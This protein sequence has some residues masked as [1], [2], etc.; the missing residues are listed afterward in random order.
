MLNPINIITE[1]G[2]RLDVSPTATIEVN[3]GGISLLDL[4]SRTATY[5]NS[6][7]LPRTPTNESVFE[8]ASQPTRN[9]RPSIN[10]WIT[11][12]LFQRKAKLKVKSFEDSYKCS[13]SYD[14]EDVIGIT[15]TF[16]VKNL[17]PATYLINAF[18]PSNPEPTNNDMVSFICGEPATARFFVPITFGHASAVAGVAC[19]KVADILDI[20]STASG[21][22]FSGDIL[23]DA[24]FL[25]T[26]YFEKAITFEKSYN[27]DHWEINQINTN[28]M[29]D[30][31]SIADILKVLAQIYA[32][33]IIVSE[34]NIELK[35]L[36][37]LL[38]NTATN[39]ETIQGSKDLYSGYANVNNIVYKT[40][41]TISKLFGSDFITDGSGEG[42][43]NIVEINS[44]IPIFYNGTLS[45]YDLQSDDAMKEIVFMQILTPVT[46][47]MTFDGTTFDTISNN[48]I[49]P[50]SMSG[51]YSGILNPIFANP[52]ILK[53]SGF[54][55]PLTA[56]TIM[57]DRIINSVR[58]GGRYWVEPMAYNFTTGQT[59]LTLIKI[60]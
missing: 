32:F 33:D 17:F 28:L 2:I 20:F 49:A 44:F 6:F 29:S 21:I 54:I 12:G 4:S 53:A 22:T 41:G 1:S 56:N 13:L 47:T 16:L 18:D 35:Q 7:D 8:F 9:N 11:K 37:D 26:V 27:V 5:T 31:K 42:Q 10:V 39:I 15:K 14:T 23:S 34:S 46:T 36:S 3:M 40:N 59:A 60:P 57:T 24:D 38:L 51:F 58:L 19:I 52:V 25:N 43:K 30:N 48:P 45:G 55:D 50:L